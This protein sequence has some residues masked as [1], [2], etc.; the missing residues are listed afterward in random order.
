[1]LNSQKPEI[2]KTYLRRAADRC[3]C[4]SVSYLISVVMHHAGKEK[5]S[6]TQLGTTKADIL[7]V[8]ILGA[9]AATQ[10]LSCPIV[11]APETPQQS[12]QYIGAA[13]EKANLGKVSAKDIKTAFYKAACV[14]A[15]IN[16]HDSIYRLVQK[17]GVSTQPL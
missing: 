2:L 3:N 10:M 8:G 4:D 7:A 14:Q 15:G 9:N 11:I 5:I 17:Q 1:M 13:L 12:I 16:L 6:L